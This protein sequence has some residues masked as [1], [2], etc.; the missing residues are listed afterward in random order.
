MGFGYTQ[1]FVI[2]PAHL[3]SKDLLYHITDFGNRA[4]ALQLPSR[5]EIFLVALF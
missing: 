2:E 4:I 1:Y 5:Q 3:A